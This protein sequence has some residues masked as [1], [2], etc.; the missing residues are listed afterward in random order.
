MTERTTGVAQAAAAGA[1]RQP[2]AA[3]AAAAAA[4]AAVAQ[5]APAQTQTNVTVSVMDS[6]VPTIPEPSS[7]AIEAKF[8]HKTLTKI[9]GQPT[10][11]DFHQLREEI[12]RNA[13][14]SKSPFGGGNHGHMGAVMD[15][16]TYT[17][18]TGGAT[19]IVP[20]TSGMFPIFQHNASD[21]TKKKRIAEF[22]RDET[23]IKVSEA[24]T[25]LLRN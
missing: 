16:I 14:S 4:I 5:P 20:A 15:G 19:W 7:D 6:Y 2:A 24:T 1:A 17:I 25:T 22:V 9:E 10:Y 3:A 18:E 12:Y 13:L 23:G 21:T 8:P 11:A